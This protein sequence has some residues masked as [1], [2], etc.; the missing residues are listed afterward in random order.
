MEEISVSAAELEL[1]TRLRSM[2]VEPERFGA[3]GE[4]EANVTKV[5]FPSEG[6]RYFQVAE[7]LCKLIATDGAYVYYVA[8]RGIFPSSENAFLYSAIEL[9]AGFQ[10]HSGPHAYRLDGGDIE[11]GA[12]LLQVAMLQAWDVYLVGENQVI[13]ISH[14]E[15]IGFAQG[16]YTMC[17][18]DVQTL[19]SDI[20]LEA[21]TGWHEV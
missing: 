4:A 6:Y 8:E 10:S 21:A 18:K 20:K 19:I 16:W 9:T 11:V 5:L 14:D 2:G 7:R 1:N 17:A 3:L 13:F 12:S 15:W